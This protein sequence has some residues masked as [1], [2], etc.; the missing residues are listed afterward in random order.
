MAFQD[1]GPPETF[2]HFVADLWI[3][4]SNR[5]GEKV[6]DGKGQPFDQVR[7]KDV[8]HQTHFGLSRIR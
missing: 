2:R 4:E 3:P 7:L 1:M 6:P 5:L 8:G